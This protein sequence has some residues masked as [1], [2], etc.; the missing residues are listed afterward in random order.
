M[1]EENEID[2]LGRAGRPNS[3][4]QHMAHQQTDHSSPSFF[5]L[6]SSSPASAIP[7]VG[8]RQSWI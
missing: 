2:S 3:P 4:L 5:V 7:N 1:N 6:Q 8:Y